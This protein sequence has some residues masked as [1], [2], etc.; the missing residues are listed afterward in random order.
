M[1][2]NHQPEYELYQEPVVKCFLLMRLS[3]HSTVDVGLPSPIP[4]PFEL[5]LGLKL[6]PLT[7][8]VRKSPRVNWWQ[9]K[10]TQVLVQ[11]ISTIPT[12]S[13][14]VFE[15][16]KLPLNRP[17]RSKVCHIENE[18]NLPQ[19]TEFVWEF[20]VFHCQMIYIKFSFFNGY[21]LKLKVSGK[22]FY[23][24]NMRV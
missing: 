24:W 17:F 10:I 11:W 23:C 6:R 9:F 1:L 19:N 7:T 21:E 20:H 5:S 15:K 3:C 4:F 18:A 2:H 22:R 16:G 8:A 14:N 12:K 13:E